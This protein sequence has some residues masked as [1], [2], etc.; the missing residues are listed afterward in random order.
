MRNTAVVSDSVGPLQMRMPRLPKDPDSVVVQG[1][2]G[3]GSCFEIPLSWP[4][5]GNRGPAVG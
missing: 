5:R 2:E 3:G 4:A 1:K